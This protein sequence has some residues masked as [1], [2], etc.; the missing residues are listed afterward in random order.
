LQPFINIIF[1][2]SPLISNFHDGDFAFPILGL[3]LEKISDGVS[4]SL[5]ELEQILHK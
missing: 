1:P 2:E 3:S 5:E 4:L